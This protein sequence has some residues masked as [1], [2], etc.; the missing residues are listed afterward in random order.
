VCSPRFHALSSAQDHGNLFLTTTD[1][2]A[3]KHINLQCLNTIAVCYSRADDNRTGRA[4]ERGGSLNPTFSFRTW[5]NLS[6]TICTSTARG[7]GLHPFFSGAIVRS[8]L[9]DT[10][11]RDCTDRT[12]S[13]CAERIIHV[14]ITMCCSYLTGRMFIQAVKA[15][16]CRLCPPAGCCSLWPPWQNQTPALPATQLGFAVLPVQQLPAQRVYHLKHPQ[17]LHREEVKRSRSPAPKVC[18]AQVDRAE[19]S[20]MQPSLLIS[21]F[22]FRPPCR[23]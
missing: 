17:G 13:C 20:A 21:V 11:R 3:V 23:L 15:L 19:S 4:C 22:A 2:D 9:Q 14:Y 1:A 7:Y 12:F 8:M 18:P 6:D 10:D 16:H 5:G